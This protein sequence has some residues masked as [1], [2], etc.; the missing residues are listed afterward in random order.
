M[1]HAENNR[2]PW[3]RRG[4]VIA[5]LVVLAAFGYVAVRLAQQQ[6]PAAVAGLPDLLG[7]PPRPLPPGALHAQ[8][9]ASDM[10]GYQ[11]TILV[12]GVLAVVTPNDPKL[13][14]MIDSREAKFCQDLKCAKFYLPVKTTGALPKPWDELNVRGKI[15]SD[16]QSTYL[17]AEHIENLGPI[18]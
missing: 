3:W 4:V 16:A 13:F 18:K 17:Q 6:F 8:D 11:G 5:L 2:K 14:G 9:L 10:K 15:V 7:T 1:N 12:R